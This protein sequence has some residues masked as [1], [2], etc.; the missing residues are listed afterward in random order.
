MP[1]SGGGDWRKKDPIFLGKPGLNIKNTKQ[2]KPQTPSDRIHWPPRGSEPSF[3]PFWLFL[4]PSRGE[5]RLC[6]EQCLGI[7]S[8][9]LQN[10]M[11]AL[12]AFVLNVPRGSYVEGSILSGS[13]NRK[14]YRAVAEPVRGGGLWRE[15]TP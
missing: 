4:L 10:A 6:Q 7:Y 8:S 3:S 9:S 14:Y 12:M 15:V 11:K 2:I 5:N 1:E 13:A